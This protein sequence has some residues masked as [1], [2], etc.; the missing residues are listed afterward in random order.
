MVT[1]GFKQ[2]ESEEEGLDEVDDNEEEEHDREPEAPVERETV[3]KKLAEV[4]LAPK[5]PER[6]L[7]KKELKKKELAELDA[8]LAELGCAKPEASGHDDSRGNINNL[9][10]SFLRIPCLV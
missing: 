5:D 6:Q 8:V 3:V 10:F 4:S 7:S 2:S 1:C 9:L